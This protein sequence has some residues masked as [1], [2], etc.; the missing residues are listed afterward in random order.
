M[1]NMSEMYG[2]QLSTKLHSKPEDNQTSQL[3]QALTSIAKPSR[4]SLDYFK[5]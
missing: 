2:N 5:R 4:G 1:G 3:K